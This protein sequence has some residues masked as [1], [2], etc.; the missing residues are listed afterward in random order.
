MVS[1]NHEMSK[2]LSSNSSVLFH[3]ENINA[4]SICVC[5]NNCVTQVYQ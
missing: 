3:S 2:H 5:L 4:T 1:D